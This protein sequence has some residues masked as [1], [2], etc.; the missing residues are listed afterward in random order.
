MREA[1]ADIAMDVGQAETET[2]ETTDP[3]IFCRNSPIRQMRVTLRLDLFCSSKRP[4]QVE[5][6]K[7]RSFISAYI[8]DMVTASE[9]IFY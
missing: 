3:G 9:M 4:C 8:L 6:K 1:K 7:T 2:T 5:V